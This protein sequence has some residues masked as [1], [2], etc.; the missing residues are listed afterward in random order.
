MP[1]FFKSTTGKSHAD[2]WKMPDIEEEEDMVAPGSGSKTSTPGPLQYEKVA[3]S[4]FI[5]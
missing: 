2:K 5:T 1:A 4:L 3:G